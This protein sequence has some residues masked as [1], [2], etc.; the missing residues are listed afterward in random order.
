MT[1]T[2]NRIALLSPSPGTQRH[3]L[4]H[5]YG[6]PGAR[7]KAYLQASIHAD[8]TPA[9]LV[10]HHL[11]HLLDEADAKGAITGEI[12][13][14]PVANPIGLSQTLNDHLLG[15]HEASGGGNF[16]RS[17]PDL[18]P[19]LPDRIAGKLGPDAARNV[20]LVRAALREIVAELTPSSEFS[21][22]RLALAS[23]A[24]DADIVLD[25][26]CDDEALMHLYSIP[27]H[28][29]SASDL[30]AEIGSRAT[31]LSEDSGGNAFDETFSN[32]WIRLAAAVPAGIPIPP[33][34]L[35]G[36]IEYRGQADT[37]D[38]IN[39]PDAEAL[40]RFLQRRGLIAGDPGPLPRPLCEATRLDATEVLRTPVAGI[41]CYRKALGDRVAKG[42]VI[43]EILDPLAQGP[44]PARLALEAGTDGLILTRRQHKMVR[45]GDCVAKIVGTEP[46]ASRRGYLL[47]D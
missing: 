30:S 25:M 13:L 36:T 12:L 32:P 6:R 35:S 9:M 5:R 7:P 11:M 45:P 29:P 34:C 28:W 46:L 44:S 20:E 22:L 23:F 3:L 1:K 15:R 41:V 39:R 2:T 14:V 40:F 26:H 21:S 10:A 19:T 43:A 27:Q 8:E 24:V 38:E 4:V 18:Y 42:E 16:N 17:W 31:L 47:Q 33:A 37:G